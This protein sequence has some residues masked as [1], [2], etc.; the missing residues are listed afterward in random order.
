MKKHKLLI[1]LLAL[2]LLCSGC[3]VETDKSGKTAGTSVTDV[4]PTATYDWMAE[5][6]PVPNRRIGIVRVGISN[7]AHA[8]SPD[9][10]YFLNYQSDG[11]YIL[12]VDHSSDTVIKLCGRPDCSHKGIDCNAFITKGSKLTY[13]NGYLY[14]MAGS[15]SEEEA[16][17][18][19]IDA[20]GSNHVEVLNLLAFA[21]ENG[22]D[23]MRCD[24]ITDGIC[25]FHTVHWVETE[26]DDPS[27]TTIKGEALDYYYYRL[28]GTMEEPALL[29]SGGILYNCGNVTLS[30]SIEA[31]ND[32]MYGSYWSWDA[33]TD[34][35]TYLTDHPGVPGYFDETQ[36]YYFKDGQI[37]RLTYATQKEEVLAETG[38]TERYVLISF[39]DCLVLASREDDETI[40]DKN[41]YFYNWD[42]ELIDTI[43]IEYA[44]SL[45]IERLVIAETAERVILSDDGATPKYYI[46]KSELGTGNA[47]VHKF[48]F[49]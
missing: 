42:F 26:G 36:G 19:R 8:V 22:G 47:K 9:G 10:V 30:Y 5:E 33:K 21:K 15:G 18:L 38:L 25:F 16:S 1:I 20:D 41:L 2:C 3:Q 11:A 39:P 45:R 44:H 13:Y 6:S 14:S 12:Y 49:S 7:A 46:E 37:C 23:Y 34:T 24:L 35:L 31:K 17:L 27:Y 29:Q 48:Q 28:D 40:A 43:A 32:G 4:E